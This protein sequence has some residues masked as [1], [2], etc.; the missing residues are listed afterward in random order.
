[1]TKLF[2]LNLIFSIKLFSETTCEIFPKDNIWNTKIDTLQV[3]PKSKIYLDSIGSSKKIKADFGSGLWNGGPI[4][5]PFMVIDENSKTKKFTVEFEYKDESDLVLYPI[6]ENPLIEGGANSKGDRHL[7][8][9]DNS[10]CLLYELFSL[11]PNGKSWKAGSG[12]IF[13]LKSNSLRQEFWTSADAAGLP[14]FPGLVRYSEIEKGEINHALRFTVKR[15]QKK[16]IWPAR[17]FAS[18]KKDENLPPMGLRIRLKKSFSIEGF[19]KEVKIILKALQEYGMILADNG[20][21]FYISGS[22]DERWDNDVLN[23]EMRK[24]SGNDFEVVETKNLILDKN[25]G[26][27]KIIK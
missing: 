7:L 2:F 24:V 17:H 10:N 9:I 6:P 25:S 21:D 4:G 14:I 5:I 15:T 8:V 16:F 11:Y 18:N 3:H 26:Q 1:M 23:K 19:S 22:P 13:N 20:S 27:V 12:A